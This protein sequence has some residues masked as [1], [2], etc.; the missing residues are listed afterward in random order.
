ML[1]QW[2]K[3]IRGYECVNEGCGYVFARLDLLADQSVPPR[4][5]CRAKE[6]TS[7]VVHHLAEATGD[8]SLLEKAGHYAKAI[9]KWTFAK[10]PVRTAEEV[11]ACVAVCES[12]EH[13]D[14]E[15]TSCKVCGCKVTAKGMAVRNKARMATED[16]PK[17]KWPKKIIVAVL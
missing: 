16:C 1:C 14:A 15:K 2:K 5:Q 4:R 9:A 8:P 13:Y 7:R 11:A 17:G 12:C 6:A 3:T 10:F